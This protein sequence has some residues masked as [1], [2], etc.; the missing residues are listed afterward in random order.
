MSTSEDAFN[1][2]RE[3]WLEYHDADDESPAADARW[4]A[5]SRSHHQEELRER[6]K[7]RSYM[8]NLRRGELDGI[9]WFWTCVAVVAF[10]VFVFASAGDSSGSSSYDFRDEQTFCYGRSGDLTC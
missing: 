7:D 2:I 8:A 4:E 1:R 9:D 6:L 3:E 5:I 10:V